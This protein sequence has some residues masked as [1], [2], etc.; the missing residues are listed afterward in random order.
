MHRHSQDGQ[1][2]Y[3]NTISSWKASGRIETLYGYC[4]YT[5]DGRPYYV[6][7]GCSRRIKIKQRNKKHTNVAAKHGWE[8]RVELTFHG[9]YDVIWSQL[10]EWETETIRAYDTLHRLD[11]IGCNFTIGGDGIRGF[12]RVK[13]EDERRKISLNKTI[14]YADPNQR[15]KLGEAISKA[16]ADPVKLQHH[17]KAQQRRY[18][19]PDERHKA[20]LANTQKKRVRQMTLDGHVVAEFPSLSYAIQKTGVKNIKLV[21]H[22]KRKVAGGYRWCYI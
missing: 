10:C 20:H 17:V 18:A 4:D 14:L 9:D 7:I 5:S 21:C 16:K 12:K 2:V 3:D 22:G 11:H 19:D 1:I 13:S 15:K 8:R 6:G